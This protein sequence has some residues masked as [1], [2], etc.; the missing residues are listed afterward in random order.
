VLIRFGAW[1]AVSFVLWLLFFLETKPLPASSNAYGI[2]SSLGAVVLALLALFRR[3]LPASLRHGT[4]SL[5]GPE[6]SVCD[7]F[8][9]ESSAITSHG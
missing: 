6:M 9:V 2:V 5:F 4:S 1:W 3:R 7:R 8:T